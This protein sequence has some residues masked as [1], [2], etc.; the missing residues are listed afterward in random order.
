[1]QKWETQ[2]TP[3]HHPSHARSPPQKSAVAVAYARAGKG[4]IKLNGGCGRTA[5]RAAVFGA[6]TR[7][8]SVRDH[9]DSISAID[10]ICHEFQT[11]QRAAFSSEIAR[12]AQCR[13][14][15]ALPANN[16][17]PGLHGSCR[18]AAGWD[19][20]LPEV[21]MLQ[22]AGA[23][24]SCATEQRLPY[25]LVDAAACATLHQPHQP[26]SSR[27]AQSKTRP[28]L[29]QHTPQSHSLFTSA[30]PHPPPSPHPPTPTPTPKPPSSTHTHQTA[31]GTPLELV[32][33]EAMRY[34]AFEPLLLLG[35][36]RWGFLDIRLRVQGGGHVSQIYA[37]RQA[38]SKAIVAYYQKNVDEQSKQ[39]V[40]GFGLFIIY[41][42]IYI[43]IYI[44]M[45]VVVAVAV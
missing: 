15:A 19:E 16:G 21:V 45:V 13:C 2:T 28:A 3:P 34:K 31:T 12:G 29:E 41:L 36:T 33:P 42:Y 5:R 8:L 30:P 6:A 9:S 38:I 37:I 40:R 20:P 24:Q 27:A 26:S 18:R 10:V 23:A 7:Q 22:S 32:Q 25:R 35:K 1:V 4:L 11:R 14:V 39:Q 43:Y 44:Y 17:W